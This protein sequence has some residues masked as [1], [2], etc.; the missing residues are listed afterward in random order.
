MEAFLG[1]RDMMAANRKIYKRPILKTVV[2][3]MS[4][5]S[6]TEEMYQALSHVVDTWYTTNKQTPSVRGFPLGVCELTPLRP[7][8][9][10]MNMPKETKNLVYMNFTMTTNPDERQYVWDTFKDKPWVTAGYPL[11]QEDFYKEL[12]NH[13]FCLCPSGNGIDTHRIWESIYV[14]TIPIVKH[15][16]VHS[17]WMELPILFVNDWSEVTPELLESV[18]MSDRSIEKAK[19]SYWV[20]LIKRV[21]PLFK[22]IIM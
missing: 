9:K 17:D 19:L 12:R 10:A 5:Y 2:T 6:V 11:P 13:R 1:Q 8:W 14:G 21:D 15:N 4:D 20:R 16:L 3:G 7:L 18:D 22:R